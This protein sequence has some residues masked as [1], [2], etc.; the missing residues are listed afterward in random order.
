MP[1]I[2]AFQAFIPAD[3][4]LRESACGAVASVVTHGEWVRGER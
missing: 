3:M 1:S 4:H 2:K